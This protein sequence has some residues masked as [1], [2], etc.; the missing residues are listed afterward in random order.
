MSGMSLDASARAA[1]NTR[2]ILAMLAAVVFFTITDAAIKVATESLPPS[3]VIVGRG[4]VSTIMVA[5]FLRFQ[6]P[7][8][9]LKLVWHPRVVQR[10]SFEMIFIVAYVIALSM[11]PFANVFSVLQ[12][13]PIMITAFAALIWRD[14]VGWR[15]WT[16]VFVGFIGVALITKPTPYGMD[17]AMV[18]A[19]LSALMVAGR[20]LTTRIMPAHV[21]SN[22]VTIASTASM[23][24]AGLFLAPFEVWVMPDA[25]AWTAVVVAGLAVAFGVHFLVLAYRTA[26]TSAISPFRYASVAFAIFAGWLIWGHVPDTL[27]MA[28]IFLIVGCGLYM[29]H[30]EHRQE[31]Q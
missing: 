28:G 21:P 2:G 8:Q 18:L 12:S 11:A 19:L 31:K 30:R 5:I 22:I 15:R 9:N 27:A 23:G 4:V 25:R 16:A 1:A 6:G 3:Q 29:M 10:M 26:E 7:F 24:V 13:A 17:I 14:P 20:D